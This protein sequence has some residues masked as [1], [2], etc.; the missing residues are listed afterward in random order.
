MDANTGLHRCRGSCVKSL[1][2]FRGGCIA[3]VSALAPERVRCFEHFILKRHCGPL[4]CS[5]RRP[6][7]PPRDCCRSDVRSNRARTSPTSYVWHAFFRTGHG[8]ALSRAEALRE[9][10][11]PCL[12]RVSTSIRGP[13]DESGF[14]EASNHSHL[15]PRRTR[16]KNRNDLPRRVR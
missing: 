10:Q 12:V 1:T 4:P 3:R 5:A 11:C 6:L 7:R 16:T 9:L 8:S 2:N 15:D 14:P 13:E